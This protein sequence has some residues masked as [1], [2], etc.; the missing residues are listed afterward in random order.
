MARAVVIVNPL[1]GRGRHY[2]ELRSH[3]ELASTLLHT[4]DIE[5]DVRMTSATG[6]ISGQ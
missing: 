6:D 3:A 4:F 5:A 2:A 1:S